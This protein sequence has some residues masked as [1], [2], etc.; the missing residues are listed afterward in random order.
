MSITN[1]LIRN[2]KQTAV[3]W[4]NPV[5]DG[6]GG[7]TYDYPVE[8]LCRWEDKNDIFVA[9]NGDEV[10]AKSF[11]YVLEDLDLNGMLYLGTID[12][13]YDP[14]ESSATTIDPKDV[15]GAFLIRRIDKLPCLGSTSNFLRKV[16][17][18]SKNMV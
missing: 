11:V 14:F 6:Y 7:F 4:G 16:F 15:P 3:Y 9:A 5:N 10:M 18:T 17:L 12:E 1:L 8:I 13:V 2:C